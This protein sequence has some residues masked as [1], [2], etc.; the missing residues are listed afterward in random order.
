MGLTFLAHCSTP[1]QYWAEA[2]QT[3]CYLI[4]RLPTPILNNH[5][6]FQTLFPSH[7]NYTF[8]S[9]FGCAC[10]P[11]LR[12]YN[13]HKLDFCSKLCTFIGYSPSHRGYK[14]LHLP[15]GRIYISRNVIFDESVFPFKASFP[16]LTTR[17]TNSHNILY[18]PS[19]ETLPTPSPTLD[20]KT[21]T[22]T[23]A[24]SPLRPLATVLPE[25]PTHPL[26]FLIHLLTLFLLLLVCIYNLRILNPLQ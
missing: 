22:P 7:P 9:V 25:S 23:S 19:L 21:P 18:P 10:W 15:T 4:N 20:A 2:F 6:P 5:S 8:M 11:H 12:P 1:L 24:P 14:C 17:P 13:H 3:S 16:S 26:Q